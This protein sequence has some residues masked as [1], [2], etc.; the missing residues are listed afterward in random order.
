M[1]EDQ[2]PKNKHLKR[3]DRAPS[4][5]ILEDDE[6]S[7]QMLSRILEKKGYAVEE[8]A[9]AADALERAGKQSFDIGLLDN[10]LP[11]MYGVDLLSPLNELRPDMVLIMITG[12]ASVENAVAALNQGAYAY[13]TKPYNMDEVLATMERAL[14]KQRLDRENRELVERL[15]SELEE[16]ERMEAALREAHEDLKARA[17]ELQETN[18]AMNVLLKK[19]E[20]DRDE[21]EAN[22]LENI[23][24]LVLPSLERL[25]GTALSNEQEAHVT[26]LEEHIRGITTSFVRELSS[27]YLNLTPMEIQVAGLIRHG[28]QTKEIA[29]MLNVSVNTILTHRYKIRSKLG[30]LNRKTNLRTY[31]NTLAA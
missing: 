21:L 8:T 13:I 25:R 14:E 22:V 15:R 29:E 11:D 20:R 16:R 10:R 30:L 28:S 9:T 18:R 6:T 24:G 23:K 12:F 5:L 1:R 2:K 17:G 26:A 4:V 3:S 27:S 7:S 19:R 31:L